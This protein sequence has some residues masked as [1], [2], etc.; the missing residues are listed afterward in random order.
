VDVVS[1]VYCEAPTV[2]QH[3]RFFADGAKANEQGPFGA[4]EYA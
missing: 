4:E 1:Y 2:R 3:D